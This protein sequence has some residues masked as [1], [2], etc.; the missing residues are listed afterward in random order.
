LLGRAASH[1]VACEQMDVVP[2]DA[3]AAFIILYTLFV[4]VVF[5]DKFSSKATR[6][7]LCVCLG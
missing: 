2:I 1:S 5:P 3:F 6:L 7:P 4:V